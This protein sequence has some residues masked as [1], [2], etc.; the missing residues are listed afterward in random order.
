M[1]TLEYSEIRS[2][3]IILHQQVHLPEGTI[4]SLDL[5]AV[6]SGMYFLKLSLKDNQRV[7]K[8]IKD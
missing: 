1:A 8:I 2:G 7:Y 5:T 6:S 4:Q 3:K